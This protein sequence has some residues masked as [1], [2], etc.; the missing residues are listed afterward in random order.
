M[1]DR[2]FFAAA[3]QR[4]K[5]L[6]KR[7]KSESTEKDKEKEKEAE[8][9][10]ESPLSERQMRLMFQLADQ[11][12]DNRISFAEFVLLNSLMQGAHAKYQFAFRLFDRNKSGAIEREEFIS[13]LK[14]LAGDMRSQHDWD[15]DQLLSDVFANKH[16]LSYAEFEAL[17]NRDRLPS[18]LSAVKH[19][20]RAIEE[21]VLLRNQAWNAG[22]GISSFARADNRPAWPSWPTFL[23]GAVAG[24]VSRTA[25]APLERIKLLFQMRSLPRGTSI[26][27]ALLTIYR[28]NGVRGFF[29]SNLSNVVRIA[30]TSALQFWFFDLFRT[31][32]WP[33]RAELS[34][35][36]RLG[37][38]SLAGAS[39]CILTY[40]LQLIQARLAIQRGENRAYR[41]IL[42]GLSQVVKYEGFRGLYAGLWPS[43]LG[44][45]PY[46]GLDFAIFGALRA[47]LP[48]TG[49]LRPWVRYANG[50]PRPHAL[51]VCGSLAGIVG[52][53][54][55]YPLDV[56]RRRLQVQN[57]K[58]ERAEKN[59]VTYKY[60]G[61]LWRTMRQI[62][63]QE[64]V[65]AL[66]SGLT[67]NLLK[68]APAVGI[69]FVVYEFAKRKLD[70]RSTLTQ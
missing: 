23:A 10:E 47:A 32:F 55:V 35:L 41:G 13:V 19:D 63:S 21:S 9:G 25:V 11:S 70:E 6:K 46:I 20:L 36:E 8:E 14:S 67:A 61:G 27:S 26:S 17:L 38:G 12:G 15:H 18:H 58:D 24:V 29:I 49:A 52:Q 65:L 43:L 62:V 22:E 56:T 48:K 60:E 1:N 45:S 50:D 3:K 42:H 64:G 39:A 54:V 16:S 31:A 40:P 51:L 30:P 7:K 59:G 4:N 28:E 5:G 53:S 44:I 69:S 34:T 57:W 68:A 33:K 2:D 66:Y 37:A